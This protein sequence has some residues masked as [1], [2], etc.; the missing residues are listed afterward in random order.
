MKAQI[1]AL[2]RESLQQALFGGEVFRTD[3]ADAHQTAAACEFFA[4][5]D[6]CGLHQHMRV[7]CVGLV[8]A[9]AQRHAGVERHRQLI[10]DNERIDGDFSHGRNFAHQ[11][12]N[13]K[14]C[15][16][17]CVFVGCGHAAEVAQRFVDRVTSDHAT[18]LRFGKRRKFHRT[19]RENLAG[20]AAGRETDRSAE[21]GVGG[22]A[23]A[24][25]AQTFAM[26]HLLHKYALKECHGSALSTAITHGVERF[27][28]FGL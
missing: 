22:S 7:S 14:K 4:R 25:F 27:A 6:R 17:E 11:S 28:H 13:L 8:A 21:Y 1:G 16:Y 5:S 23:D 18:C 26:G 2:L 15:R 19:F 10:V 3:A 24:H 20:A 9:G 12:G